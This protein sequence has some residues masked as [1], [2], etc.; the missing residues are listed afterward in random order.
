MAPFLVQVC[1]LALFRLVGV[2]AWPYFDNW[3]TSLRAAVAVMFLFTASAH[4]GKRR[5]D[6]IRLVPRV[7]PKPEWIVAVTGRLEIAGAIGM[8][9]P[10]VARYASIC[11]AILLAAMF[12]ANIHAARKRMTIAGKPVTPLAL[13]TVLQ[14]VFLAAVLVAGI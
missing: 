11:L 6:L 7:F 14:I 3:Q 4:W 8:M 5:R 12:P 10:T 2:A 13:R 9:I 1:S